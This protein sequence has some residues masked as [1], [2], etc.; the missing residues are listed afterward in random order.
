MLTIFKVQPMNAFELNRR[1]IIR[2]TAWAGLGLAWSGAQAQT[3]KLEKTK[4][5]IAVGGK[6]SFIICP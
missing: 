4:V 2:A 3:G 6:A 5:S 1:Q